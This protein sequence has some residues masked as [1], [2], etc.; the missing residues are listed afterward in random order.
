[1]IPNVEEFVKELDFDNKKI[2]VEVPR[3]LLDI[4]K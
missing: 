1:M 2:M 3:E 4:N